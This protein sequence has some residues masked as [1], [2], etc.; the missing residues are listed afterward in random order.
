[1]AE[2][3]A[4]RV[5][6]AIDN[7]QLFRSVQE[8]VRQKDDFLAMLSHE[9]RNPLAAIG[10]ATALA[11]LP[12]ANPQTDVFPVI[13]RQVTHL[14]HLIDD[15]L[16]VARISRDKI[17]LKLETIDLADA[18]RHAADAARPLMEEKGHEFVV[19][20]SA[21]PLPVVADVT[22]AEQV[23]VNLL[24]NS[25][26]YTPQG[27]RVLFQ[28]VP[29]QRQAI[30]KVQDNGIGLAPEIVTKVFDL[31]AQ[32]DRTL[33]RSEG[34]LGIG[35]TIVRKLVEM[36]GGSVSAS[37]GGLGQGA[38]FVV[39]LP[40]AAQAMSSAVA[41]TPMNEPTNDKQRL[42]VVDDNVDTARLS[43][44]M[45]RTQGF[46]VETANDGEA[47]LELI[48]SNR[49]DG[50]LLDIGLPRM[51]GYEVAQTLRGEGFAGKL[52]AVSG[53]GQAED[54]RKS[55]EAGFDHHLVKPVDHRHLIALLRGAAAAT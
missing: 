47:A 27:G 18:A 55:Q 44:M 15:L 49:P 10:Y 4:Q 42:V 32:G 30:I 5:A 38:E 9:L 46:E 3:L 37:S 34:G 28:V 21:E 14:K 24:T 40:L 17:N 25:A 51:N 35:L 41:S 50:V 11:Q 7:S 33:D 53:Y 19:E 20:I 39:R 26:K 12:N 48:R 1:V 31:F 2:D 13:E 6:T 29:E 43:A 22:R 8:A 36:H 54:R 23:M 52:I 16:D 45:L